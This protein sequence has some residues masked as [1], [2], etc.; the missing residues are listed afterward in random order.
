MK[1]SSVDDLSAKGFPL[2][3]LYEL[4]QRVFQDNWSIPYKKE[5]AFGQCLEAAAK[6]A[7]QGKTVS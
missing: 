7:K 6:L 4:E 1:D 3:R 2:K 5:E